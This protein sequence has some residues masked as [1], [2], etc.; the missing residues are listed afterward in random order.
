MYQLSLTSTM[1]VDQLEAFW[2]E[3]IP[4]LGMTLTGK[5]T[6][7]GVLT[8]AITNPDGGIVAA[9]DGDGGV[10]IVISLGTSA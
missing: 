2:D 1:T 10:G 3:R 8:I 4:S 5:F 7:G 6:S 9:P